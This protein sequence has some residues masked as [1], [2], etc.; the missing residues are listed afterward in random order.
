MDRNR[1][2]S[3]EGLASTTLS[4]L[5]IGNM[6][7]MT[8]V[9]GLGTIPNLMTISELVF[10]AACSTYYSM[11]SWLCI[12]AGLSFTIVVCIHVAFCFLNGGRDVFPSYEA[13][14]GKDPAMLVGAFT[15]STYSDSSKTTSIPGRYHPSACTLTSTTSSDHR[16]H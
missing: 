14:L 5:E 1:T 9:P 10:D 8:H 13:G 12:V 15:I 11:L 2:R 3:R 6:T 16:R 4:V 7:G